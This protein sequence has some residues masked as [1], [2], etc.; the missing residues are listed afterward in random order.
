MLLQQLPLWF[1]Y[2]RMYLHSLCLPS[3]QVEC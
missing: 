1:V 3:E 2:T